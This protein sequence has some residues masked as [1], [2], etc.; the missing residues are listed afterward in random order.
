[1]V[2]IETPRQGQMQREQPRMQAHSAAASGA[3]EVASG[4][5]QV[6]KLF[7]PSGMPNQ[8]VS[9]GAMPHRKWTY[10]ELMKMGSGL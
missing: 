9:E 7:I 5:L 4:V 2:N 1:M 10:G 6:A 8:H 3:L